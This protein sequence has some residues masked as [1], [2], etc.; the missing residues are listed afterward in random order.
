MEG[1]NVSSSQSEC[2]LQNGNEGISLT[3]TRIGRSFQNVTFGTIS[4]PSFC[5]ANLLNKIPP[6][7]YTAVNEKKLELKRKYRMNIQWKI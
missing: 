5:L 2:L 6:I 4:V 7:K 1:H 3:L